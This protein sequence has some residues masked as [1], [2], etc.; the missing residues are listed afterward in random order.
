MN[1][2]IRDLD[3][4]RI[5]YEAMIQRV[6]EKDA[7]RAFARALSH[8]GRKGFTA[9]KRAVRQ[10]SDIPS[11]LVNAGVKF[12][13][14]RTSELRT[15]IS[16]FGSELPLKHFKARQFSYGVRAKIWGR[17]QTFKSAFIIKA[18]DANVFIRK[19]SKRFPVEK[20]WGPSIPKELVKDDS[21]KAF[22]NSNTQIMDRA[23]HELSRILRV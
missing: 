13:A 11:P 2:V 9:V 15:V 17:H 5:R 18:Y 14:A 6:G 19:T 12:K 8:E 4:T 20:L 3:N 7:N 23:M 16:G 22:E 21:L 1:L 10:Q